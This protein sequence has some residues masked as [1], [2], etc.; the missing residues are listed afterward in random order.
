MNVQKLPAIFLT[1][2]CLLLFTE[3]SD[4]WAGDYPHPDTYVPSTA[5]IAKHK[6]LINDPR[7]VMKTFGVHKLVPQSMLDEMK[8]D[9]EEM[10]KLWSEL[11]G[12]KAPDVVGKVAP[13]IKPGKYTWEEVAK[14]PGF[15]KLFP[16]GYLERIRKA[17]PPLAGVFEEIEIIPTRQYY[18]P[19]PVAKATQQNL[20]KT[21]LDEQGY[22]VEDT[23]ESGYPFPRP[24]GKHMVQQIMNNHLLNYTGFGG[25]IYFSE[26]V[27]GWNKNLKV[28]FNNRYSNTMARLNGRVNFTPYGA[29]SDRSRKRKELLG[30]VITYDLPRDIAGQT[31]MSISFYP[32]DKYSQNVMYLP[33]FRRVR[34]LS[35]TDTQDPMVGFS[36]SLDDIAGFAQ[37]MSPDSFPIRY[38]L[39]SEGE[40]LVP[41]ATEDGSFTYTPEGAIVGQKFERR[42]MW[43]VRLVEL[44]PN[45]VYSK[46]ILYIDKE[47]LT[48]NLTYMYDQKGRKYRTFEQGFSWQPEFGVYSNG[49]GWIYAA[50]HVELHSELSVSYE[51]PAVYTSRDISIKKMMR[52]AK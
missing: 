8:W 7:P 20:G 19:L 35:S 10:K 36:N 50:D 45:Y 11:V 34:K 49:G 37:K 48:I 22:L 38:E 24:S 42:P 16:E 4:L 39:E 33:A 5:E 2:T 26:N 52:R 44:D 43:V 27:M 18:M 51:L 13:E 1:A 28:D 17:G 32:K 12:F 29:L 9:V 47:T 46:R 41:A 21:K 6:R 30:T 23:W 14:A 40:F 3:Y 15:K 31:L 25:N